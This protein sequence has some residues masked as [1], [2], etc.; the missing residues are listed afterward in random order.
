MTTPIRTILEEPE[1][2]F[3]ERV[4]SYQ[5]DSKSDIAGSVHEFH[6]YNAVG[7]GHASK[8]HYIRFCA[9]PSLRVIQSEDRGL[10]DTLRSVS[11]EENDIFHYYNVFG[12]SSTAPREVGRLLEDVLVYYFKP[13]QQVRQADTAAL[14]SRIAALGRELRIDSVAVK[15]RSEYQNEYFRFFTDAVPAADAHQFW[16]NTA[17]A[18][19]TAVTQANA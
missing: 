14:K 7:L 5:V 13:D 3:T 10:A 18:E 6:H 15:L 17:T 2:C 9:E 19:M 1:I 4:L 12:I 8:V 16:L 11:P